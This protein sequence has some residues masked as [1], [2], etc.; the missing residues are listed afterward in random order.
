MTVYKV[1]RTGYP[2]ERR[3]IARYKNEGNARKRLMKERYD[4]PRDEDNYRIV[5]DTGISLKEEKE[6][7][8]DP[9]FRYRILVNVRYCNNE[10][11]DENYRSIWFDDYEKAYSNYNDEDFIRKVMPERY[12]KHVEDWQIGPEIERYMEREYYDGSVKYTEFVKEDVT[13]CNWCG[14][15]EYTPF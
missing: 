8:E 4:N 5:E 15:Y 6:E 10:T 7:V 13:R 14:D 1:R 3:L 2:E 11:V 12:S 9:N